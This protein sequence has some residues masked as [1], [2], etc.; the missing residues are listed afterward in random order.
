MGGAKR[1]T[2]TEERLA[3]SIPGPGDH[4]L[5]SDFDKKAKFHM[6]TSN[7]YDPIKREKMSQPG[8]GDHDPIHTS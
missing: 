2:D 8:P 4:N 6:G 7:N 1:F 5:K 3:K